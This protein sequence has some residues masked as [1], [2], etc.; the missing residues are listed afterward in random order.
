M[1][2]PLTFV[3]QILIALQFRR[4]LTRSESPGAGSNRRP[5][6]YQGRALPT[7]LPGHFSRWLRAYGRSHPNEMSNHLLSAI[8]RTGA[9]N[10]TRTRDPELGRLALYQLSYSRQKGAGL[11][12]GPQTIGGEGRIRTSEAV[13][14]QIYSLLPLATREPLLLYRY[15]K[16]ESI[17][18]PVPQILVAGCLSETK[19]S[20]ARDFLLAA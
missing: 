10:G 12:L 17:K 4:W 2:L 11:C 3:S 8:C 14:R 7:E 15:C 18:Q 5:R 6:P 9:G 13:R 19:D 20:G 1:R 16:K